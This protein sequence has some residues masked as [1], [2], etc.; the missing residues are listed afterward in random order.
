MADLARVAWLLARV[1]Y[2]EAGRVVVLSREFAHDSR[3]LAG[4]RDLDAL[5][6]HDQERLERAARQAD[7]TR[8]N[9]LLEFFTPTPDTFFHVCA[10]GHEAGARALLAHGISF[11]GK[12]TCYIDATDAALAATGA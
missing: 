9:E 4:W 11:L 5:S 2:T 10:S 7:L 1:G 6:G 12:E 8:L 3:L